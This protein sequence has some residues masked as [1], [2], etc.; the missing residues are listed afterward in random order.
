MLYFL[1]AY[2]VLRFRFLS[3][4]RTFRMHYQK[5]AGILAPTI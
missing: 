2:H 4:V 5:Y 3:P 1:S